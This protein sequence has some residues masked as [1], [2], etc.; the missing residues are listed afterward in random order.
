MVARTARMLTLSLALLVVGCPPAPPERTHVGVTGTV[1]EVRPATGEL[2]LSWPDT[3]GT[4]RLQDVDSFL[5]TPDSEIYV[6]DRVSNLADVRVGDAIEVLGYLDTAP[7]PVRVIVSLA[8][9]WRHEPP[10]P[11]PDLTPL[12][13]NR[14]PERTTNAEE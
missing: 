13:T 2:V 5:L 12:A 6:D 9:V 3:R 4:R 14:A 1:Q 8:H 7:P 11:A 10:P